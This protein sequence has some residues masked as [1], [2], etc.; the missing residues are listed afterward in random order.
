MNICPT[1]AL[2]KRP[3]GIVDLYGDICI[4]CRACMVACPYDQLFIDPN[5]RTAEK[6]NFC[7]NRVENELQPAC[8]SVCPTECRIFGDMDDPTSQVSQNH[9]ARVLHGPQ[10]RKRHGTEGLLPRRGR[11]HA[12]A[13]DC[14]AAV[15]VQGRPGAPAAARRARSPI[16][17]RPG[18]PRVDYDV[19][20]RKA[21]G[22]DLVMYLMTKGISTG[23]M[24]ISVGA[25]AQ[26]R[27]LA[28]RRLRR[29]R[30][31]RSCSPI[32]TAFVLVLD[33]ERPGA[34]PADPHA[35]ELDVVDGARRVHPHGARRAG[36]G[37]AGGLCASA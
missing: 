6:C 16:R 5:T 28:A 33:L 13:G 2:Y 36:D 32:L 34:L 35:A 11:G 8:V 4:G 17:T 37:L 7:A 9:P 29:A 12:P 20:H 19:P 18:D 15:P 14:G 30:S 25:L 26:R 10:A 24:M 3:D 23:A 22:M 27:S 31:S 21:W 1:S